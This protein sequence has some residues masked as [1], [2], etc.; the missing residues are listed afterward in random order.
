[1]TWR[2]CYWMSE[3]R[4]KP[5][6][7]DREICIRKDHG[8]SALVLST[9]TE[10]AL[11]PLKPFPPCP[12]HLYFLA[13]QWDVSSLTSLVPCWCSRLLVHWEGRDVEEAYVSGARAE[14]H[15]A[16][17]SCIRLVSDCMVD[18]NAFLESSHWDTQIFI[19]AANGPWLI[20]NHRVTHVR[21]V[22]PQTDTVF[23]WTSLCDIQCGVVF[24]L[25]LFAPSG[26]LIHMPSVT[27][28]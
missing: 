27:S 8:S 9:V 13:C 25:V 20:Q 10:Q 1:M 22:Q 18:W 14:P 19:I 3:W 5:L 28:H 23:W 12:Q 17:L 24:E 26:F 21:R 11:C 2:L 16:P 15:S 7:A 4:H 6:G